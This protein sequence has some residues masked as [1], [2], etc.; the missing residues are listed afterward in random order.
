M[1]DMHIHSLFSYDSE[2]SPVRIAEKA[3]AIGLSRIAI[4]DHC[5]F[6]YP[7]SEGQF[8]RDYS[9]Y[10]QVLEETRRF[11]PQASLSIGLE[12]GFTPLGSEVYSKILS[13]YPF[14]YVINSVHVPDGRADCYCPEDFEGKSRAEAYGLYL[15]AVHNSIDAPYHYD[16]IGHL[17]YVCRNAPYKAP[18]FSLKT[19]GDMLDAILKKIIHKG[20]I[21][22]IN[23]SVRSAG[24]VTLPSE[25]ILARYKELGGEL[26]TFGSDAHDC[27]RINDG[28]ERASDLAKA[29]GFKYF[30]VVSAKKISM[31]EIE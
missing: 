6:A 31:I 20:K 18:A 19:E 29:I 10:F 1:I 15:E 17:G 23:T 28:Y 27:S 11:V 8:V 5:D 14:D 3:A 12:V 26:I 13:T 24:S 2:E 21:L 25:S 4:T 30:A 16:A 7:N 9:T 22:E